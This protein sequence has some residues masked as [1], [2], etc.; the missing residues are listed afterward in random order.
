MRKFHLV[1]GLLCW[2]LVLTAQ[3][4]DTLVQRFYFEVE[5]EDNAP[6]YCE[7]LFAVVADFW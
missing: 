7:E 6:F 5:E 4:K 2:V 1:C 3:E